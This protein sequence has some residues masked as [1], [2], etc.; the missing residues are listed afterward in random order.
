MMIGG[1]V[2]IQSKDEAA[3]KAFFR[4]VLKFPHVD[5]GE[6]FLLFAL[7]PTE[8]AIHE[9]ENNG[10]HELYLMCE[11]MDD[12]TAAMEAEGVAY[13]EPA[14]RG[15][16]SVTAITLPG[17][18]KLAVYQPHH[19]RPHK[20]SAKP[21][22]KAAAKKKARPAKAAKRPAKKKAV[23]SAKKKATKKKKSRR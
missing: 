3:D 23:K 6:G 22:R 19:E 8:V 1:H 15:W 20:A 16:G 10:G 12:F 18:G 7:P 2:M 13:N 11:D 21:A 9:S 5:A 17:G 14:N 4:D